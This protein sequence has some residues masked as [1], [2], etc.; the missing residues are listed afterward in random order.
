MGG[1]MSIT[2]DDEPTKV[3]V[4]IVD[5]ITG[6]HALAGILTALY[7]REKTGHGLLVEVNLLTSLLSGLVNQSAA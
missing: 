6:L 2:G 5:V 7:Q 3:G 1:L 4:A